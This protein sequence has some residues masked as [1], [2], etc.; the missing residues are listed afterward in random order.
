MIEEKRRILISEGNKICKLLFKCDF[1]QK[2]N[3]FCCERNILI[4]IADVIN[5]NKIKNKELLIEAFFSIFI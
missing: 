3:F 2:L 4:N 5:V 1:A